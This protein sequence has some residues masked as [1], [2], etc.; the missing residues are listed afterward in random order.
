[1]KTHWL[2][3]LPLVLRLAADDPKGAKNKD[4]DSLQGAWA[5]SSVE[6]GGEKADAELVKNLKVVVEGDKMTIK[7]ESAELEK[8]GKATLKIDASTTPKIIDI[9]ITG[10]DEKGTTFEGI[11]EVNKDEWKLC[12]KLA[13][14]ERPAKLES[15]AGSQDVL[16]VFQREKK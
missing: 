13:G 15:A 11:Y 9:T 14:K 7:G 5:A 3:V 6:Y 10:G 12:V 8:Y 16:V 1:M 4:L 2:T